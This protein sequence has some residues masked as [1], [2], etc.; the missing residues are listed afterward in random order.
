MRQFIAVSEFDKEGLL[1]IGGKDFRYFRNVLRLCPGDMISVRVPSGAL[2]NATLA[3]VD[4]RR[5]CAVLQICDTVKFPEEH[6]SEYNDDTE[7]YLFQFVAKGS[8]MDLIVRQA[9]EC[10]VCKIIP[11]AGEYAQA[12]ATEK[13][14]RNGRYERII[15]E[16]R[17]QSGSPVATEI[18]NTMTLDD[19]LVF[20]KNEISGLEAQSIA[21][22]LYERIENTKNLFNAVDAIKEIKKCALFCGSEGGISP[23]EIQ[24][25]CEQ[26]I[27]PVHF[28][29]NILRCETAALYGIACMQN[30]VTGKKE[31]QIKK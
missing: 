9:T 8:K 29:T 11:V 3:K 28:E 30:L 22:V 7:F 26:G 5:R 20:W 25:L 24:F 23:G 4:E 16:A 2:V 17:Q 27:I 21:C 31:W 13:S 15:K 12:G 1:Q 19:A 6:Q 10:G 18:Y 14:F